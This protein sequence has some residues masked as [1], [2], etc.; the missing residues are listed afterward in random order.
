M[1]RKVLLPG[2]K[3]KEITKLAIGKPGGMDAEADK[4]DH[5]GRVFCIP[6]KRELSIEN[7]TV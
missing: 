3:P 5:H 4:W 2:E 7:P 1:V 6:C